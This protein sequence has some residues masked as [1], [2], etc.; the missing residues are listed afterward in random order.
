MLKSPAMMKSLGLF[1][2]WKKKLIEKD[3]KRSRVWKWRRWAVDDEDSKKCF[4]DFKCD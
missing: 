2:R 1:W 4:G 3:G